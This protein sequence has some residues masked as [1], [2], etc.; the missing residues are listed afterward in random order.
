MKSGPV[1]RI[2]MLMV[3]A[4]V[5]M[6]Q[7]S[8]TFSAIATVKTAGGTTVTT[9][10]KVT[11]DRTTP[12]PEADTLVAAFKASGV[13]GLRKALKGVPP[14]GSIRVGDRPAVP[15]RIT[16]ER[17]TDKGRLLTIVTDAPLVF[18]GA[19]A[20][21]AKPKSGYDFAVLDLE[22]GADGSGPGTLAPAARISVKGGAF[23]VEDY[24][25]EIVRLTVPR[26]R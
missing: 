15:T 24:A 4:C 8:E 17:T 18:L 1:V 9:P 19:G 23:V 10:I 11:I 25:A 2:S 3:L 20:P 13:E 26:V 12:Q 22:I 6:V 21:D 14:T 5:G 7:G 16:L